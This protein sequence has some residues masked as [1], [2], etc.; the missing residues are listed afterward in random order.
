[1]WIVS[2]PLNFCMTNFWCHFNISPK[3][4]SFFCPQADKLS[5]GDSSEPVENNL[6]LGKRTSRR[7]KAMDWSS[8]DDLASDGSEPPRVTTRRA[9]SDYCTKGR[10]SQSDEDN[11]NNS[12]YFSLLTY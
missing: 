10:S 5:G 6:T 9:W 4:A 7:E 2:N 12:V 1:M 3:F 8:E 11:N